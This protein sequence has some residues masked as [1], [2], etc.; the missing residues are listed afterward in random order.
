MDHS[1]SVSSAERRLSARAPLFML[2]QSNGSP[3][4]FF[5]N[6][7]GLGGMLCQTKK[8][9]WPGSFLDVRF[10]LPETAEPLTSGAQVISLDEGKSKTLS[11]GLRFCNLSSKAELA[12]YRFLDRRRQLW[13]ERELLRLYENYREQQQE[14]RL[15]DARFPF[16]KILRRAYAAIREKE[17]KTSVQENLVRPIFLPKRVYAA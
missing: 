16:A 4:A 7:I 8:P 14:Q 5:A 13:D 15:E 10:Q 9:R 17:L 12:I 3:E 6:D 11:M 2:V 1:A